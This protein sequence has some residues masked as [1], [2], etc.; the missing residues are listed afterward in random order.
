[1]YRRKNNFGV[2]HGDVIIWGEEIFELIK[3]N[4]LRTRYN[5]KIGMKAY[6]NL[7]KEGMK[8]LSPTSKYIFLEL[9]KNVIRSFRED[10]GEPINENYARFVKFIFNNWQGQQPLE[11]VILNHELE[12]AYPE[13][14]SLATAA[15]FGRRRRKT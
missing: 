3:N 4:E 10:P 9:W 7:R 14:L 2:S 11:L 12:V 8:T 6:S 1:M 15:A 13:D 5:E